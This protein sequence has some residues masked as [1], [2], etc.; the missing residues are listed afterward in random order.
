MTIIDIINRKREGEELS[1][2]E[3]DFWIDGMMSGEI[4]D[5]Q[6]S[7]LLMAIVLK[8]MTFDEAYFLTDAMVNSGETVNLS[9]IDGIKVDK[10]STGGVGDKIT[11]ILAPLLASFGIKIAKMS[12]R[13]LGHTGGTI[14]KLESIPGFKVELSREE[15][16]EQ[17]RNIG[18]AIISQSG[19]LV[20]ADKKLYALRDITGTVSSI[21]LIASSIMSKKI[22][23][24]SDL[25]FIDVKVG[26][27]ALMQ[28]LEEASKL[29]RTMIAIGA[30]SEKTVI[31]MLT[32]MDEPLGYAIGN[33]L[34]IKEAIDTLSGMGPIDVIELVVKSASMIVSRCLNIDIE[35]AKEQCFK[36]INNGEALAKFEEMVKAQGGDLSKLEFSNRVVSIR[37][38]KT[39]Y[40]TQINTLGLGELAKQIG[41]GRIKKEDQIS[42]KVGI[43]LNCKIGDSVN[44]NEELARVYL[45]ELDAKLSDFT[46][47]FT[48]ETEACDRPQVIH[49]IIQ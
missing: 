42:Y 1:K 14:D 37:S 47:C 36:K 26:N 45:D 28:T 23:S 6:I 20:P 7:A 44:T 16:I 46:S 9:S 39:G 34:E 17:T 15:F 32:N 12:G 43:V 31:C 5:Y 27:G 38:P 13:G 22:A 21:P 25:I 33:S 3:I 24:G 11:I 4:P 35:E 48:I 30:K 10:H 40:I 8:G 2:T 18:L 19:N 41:A 49:E 29:A